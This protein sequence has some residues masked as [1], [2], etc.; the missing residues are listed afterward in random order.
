M[1]ALL[2]LYFFLVGFRAI[3]LLGTGDAVAMLMGAALIILPLLGCW[4]LVR[5]LRFGYAATRL[6]DQLDAEDALPRGLSVATPSG[7]P[8]RA[9]ADAVFPQIKSATE[10][11]P[12]DWRNWMRLAII[13]DASGDRKRARAATR[14]AISLER[15]EIR[16]NL[17]DGSTDASLS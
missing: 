14:E 12:T 13:Y 17:A 10:A 8:S 11:E 16:S 2:I 4:A 3:V 9:D 6:V 15:N 1:S 5:E 7:K